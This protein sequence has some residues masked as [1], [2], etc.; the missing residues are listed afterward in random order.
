[1]SGA[2]GDDAVDVRSVL[3]FVEADWPLLGGDFVVRDVT[4]TWRGSWRPRWRPRSA[5]RREIAAVYGRLAGA[6][7]AA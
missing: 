4:V 7:P 3:C 5:D 2:L 1:M 6:F